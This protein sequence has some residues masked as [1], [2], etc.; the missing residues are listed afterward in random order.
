M[1]PFTLLAAGSTTLALLNNLSNTV[2]RVTELWDGVLHV[3]PHIED[4]GHELKNLHY[5]IDIVKR[6][7]ATRHPGTP[8]GAPNGQK[9][10]DLDPL[11][12]S[13]IH[14][15]ESLEVIFA[16][17]IRQRSVLTSVRQSYR[18]ERYK[19]E[20]AGLR[21]RMGIYISSI[22]SAAAFLA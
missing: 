12:K 22:S 2:I 4:M 16:D 7:M 10:N 9:P 13:A 20:I 18:W 11:L 1:D 17:L 8:D 19:G 21:G 6:G 5:F 15:L 14:T 3:E